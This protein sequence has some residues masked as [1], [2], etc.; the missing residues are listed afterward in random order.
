MLKSERLSRAAETANDFITDQ[1]RAVAAAN[2]LYLCHIPVRGISIPPPV[3]IGSI[4][5]PAIVSLNSHVMIRSISCALSNVTASPG[6][7]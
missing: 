4:I 3:I 7:R 6:F 1:K 5:T 2:V